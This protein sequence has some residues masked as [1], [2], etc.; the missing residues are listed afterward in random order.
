MQMITGYQ[1]PSGFN[2]R[3]MLDVTLFTG[4]IYRGIVWEQTPGTTYGIMKLVVK[5]R[6][7]EIPNRLIKDVRK[8]NSLMTKELLADIGRPGYHW[9]PKVKCYVYDL[10]D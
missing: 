5:D 9:E 4:E 8:I 10:F 7:I 1:S 3:P 2:K 6:L